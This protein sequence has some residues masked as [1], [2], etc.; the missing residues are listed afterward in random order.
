MYVVPFVHHD[1]EI[2]RCIGGKSAG[3]GDMSGDEN[4]SD[5]SNFGRD[6][7]EAERQDSAH[8]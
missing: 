5:E 7:Y 2:D 8:D 1:Q 3:G 4:S 6:E